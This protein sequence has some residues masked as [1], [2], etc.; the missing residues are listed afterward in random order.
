VCNLGRERLARFGLERAQLARTHPRLVVVNLTA[1]GTDGPSEYAR[2]ARARRT[3]AVRMGRRRAARR[4]TS[5]C[6]SRCSG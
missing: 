6:T 5:R 2:D 3:R 4:S 1:Y